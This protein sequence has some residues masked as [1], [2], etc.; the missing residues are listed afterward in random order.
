M[1][2]RRVWLASVL[3]SAAVCL[4]V[5]LV[6]GNQSARA[7]DPKAKPAEKI[8]EHKIQDVVLKLPESW[9]SEKPENRLR[10]AQFVVP[11]VAGDDEKPT[12]V[13]SSFAGGGVKENMSR[14]LGEFKDSV[15]VVTKSGESPQ[16]PYELAEVSGT[17]I[18]P[19]FR[20]REVP[21]KDGHAVNLVLMPKD[22]PY[23]Y[24]KLTGPAKSVDAAA[25]VLRESIGADVTKE[26]ATER[27]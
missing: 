25:K 19:S 24:L 4:S 15:K 6:T 21:M 10:L 18:G 12:L 26:K 8:V 16:G 22:K 14:W 3:T 23:Y 1:I 20:R 7:A 13:V 2:Q 9:Q 27:E 5:G 11:S 17:W